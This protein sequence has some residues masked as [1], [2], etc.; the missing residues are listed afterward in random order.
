MIP[1]SAQQILFKLLPGG[2]GLKFTWTATPN[3][4]FDDPN[5]KSPMTRPLVNT[6]YHVIARIG[7]CFNEDD[8]NV[9]T[10]PY[11]VVDAGQDVTICYDDTVY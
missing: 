6:N 11:P 9:V 3:A 5:M 1:R 2:D 10:I 8:L 7:K 4:Y